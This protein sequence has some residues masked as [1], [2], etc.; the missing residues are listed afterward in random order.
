MKPSNLQT[1]RPGLKALL[2]IIPVTIYA[3]A[4]GWKFILGLVGFIILGHAMNRLA[5]KILP[6]PAKA[7]K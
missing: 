3:S 4:L 1:F 5:E 6:E 7:K 2:W